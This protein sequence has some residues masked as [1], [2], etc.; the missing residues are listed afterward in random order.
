MGCD[1]NINHPEVSGELKHWGKWML[2]SIGIDG[3]RLDALKH[4]DGNFCIDWISDRE[5][6]FGLVDQGL[7]GGFGFDKP[8][9]LSALAC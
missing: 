6:H 3:F 8:A 1:L 2:D 4:I 9:S 5:T 7:L